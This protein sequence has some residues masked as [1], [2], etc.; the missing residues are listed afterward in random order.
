TRYIAR[1]RPNS[2]LLIFKYERMGDLQESTK[3]VGP[4]RT[5]PPN[6]VDLSAKFRV[7]GRS[8]RRALK[9]PTGL[10]LLLNSEYDVVAL[11]RKSGGVAQNVPD[12][13][14]FNRRMPVCPEVRL[15][16]KKPDCSSPIV[17]RGG[18]RYIPTSSGRADHK[19]SVRRVCSIL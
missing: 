14:S 7:E 9:R 13:M 8:A 11:S 1:G 16:T 12:H 10:R 5:S 15:M 17:S 4:L 2:K 18:R 3:L 6:F 19:A